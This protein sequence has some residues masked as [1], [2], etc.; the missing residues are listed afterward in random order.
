MN[1]DANPT[2]KK[3]IEMPLNDFETLK[4]IGE[5][6][7][8]KVRLVKCRKDNKLYALKSMS[9]KSIL[10]E[11]QIHRTLGE[12]QTLL[13]IDHPFLLSAKY[14]M[15]TPT[16][17]YFVT[18]Y[19]PGGELSTRIR[20]EEK[21][22]T[23][24]IRFYGAMIVSAIGY[25]HQNEII[26][27]DLKPQNILIDKD[28][29]FRIIDFGLIKSGMKSHTLTSTFCGTPEYIPPEMIDQVDGG[30]D[31]GIDWWQLG[32]I[33]YEMKYQVTP[34]FHLSDHKIFKSILIDDVDFPED[35]PIDPD[36]KDLIT[37]LLN[38]FPEERIGNGFK[39]A[40]EII[41][42]QFF[43]SIDFSKLEAKEYEMP[44]KPPIT[45]LYDISMFNHKYT[46]K[47]P[48]FSI[49]D[50]PSNITES[51]QRLFLNFTSEHF[52]TPKEKTQ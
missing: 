2:P 13:S 19:V 12:R 15:Q 36:L 37:K 21:F 31:K 5:G 25:L 27:R 20:S 33:L 17:V 52:D 6:A 44:W 28:G 35:I 26:H 16:D 3:N 10:E 4:F 11:N 41:D 30:Y 32:I 38:K 51:A 45:D 8:G 42:H 46:D 43:E 39:D 29:Y 1:D 34:F 9:K 23:E 48:Q 50:Q 47:N 24:T 7:Y 40:S 14:C 49:D 18:E 22:S